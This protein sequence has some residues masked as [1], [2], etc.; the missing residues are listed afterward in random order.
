VL[1]GDDVTLQN[2]SLQELV[3]SSA[4]PSSFHLLGRRDDVS[5]VISA[6]TVATLTSAW[7]EAFPLSIGEAMCCETPCIAT[8][9]GDVAQIVGT[10]GRIVPTGDAGALSEAWFDLLSMSP[11]ERRDLGRAARAHVG[12]HFSLSAVVSQYET[13]YRDVGGDWS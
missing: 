4:S 3:A 10:T 2:P 11:T 8:D 1:C 7:G 5:R 12:R 9:V 13:L 6:F